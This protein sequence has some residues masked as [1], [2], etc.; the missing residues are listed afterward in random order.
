M[1]H[2]IPG[3]SAVGQPFRWI[4][5]IRGVAIGLS[6]GTVWTAFIGPLTDGPPSIALSFALYATGCT[7]TGG[8]VGA[9]RWFPETVGLLVCGLVLTVLARIAGP[10]SPWILLWMMIFGGSGLFCGAV[11]GGLFRLLDRRSST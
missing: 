4:S 1:A 2:D 11:I 3:Q 8:M 5:V 9:I 7:V 6:V 10:N